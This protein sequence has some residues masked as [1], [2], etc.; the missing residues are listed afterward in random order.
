MGWLPLRRVSALS[1]LWEKTLDGTL[2]LMQPQLYVL[3][4]SYLAVPC[5]LVLAYRDL[6]KQLPEPLYDWRSTF[7]VTSMLVIAADW[8]SVIL[9]TVADRANLRWAKP[10]DVNW[11]SYLGLA[12]IV[13]ALLALALNGRARDWTIAAS[14]SMA[15][16]WAMGLQI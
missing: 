3:V 14:L 9:L 10:I 8:C 2:R 6:K 5:L 1:Q 4:L 11:F 7:G 16:F 12:P 13:A 15:V